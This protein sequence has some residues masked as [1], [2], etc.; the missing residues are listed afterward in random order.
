MSLTNL[1]AVLAFTS[2]MLSF[3]KTKEGGFKKNLWKIFI[4]SLVGL[5]VLIITFSKNSQDANSVKLSDS[6]A[7]SVRILI[8]TIKNSSVI[9]EGKVQKIDTLQ[10]YLR[11][12]DSL[13]I[14]RDSI[15]NLPIVTKN[16][17]NNIR[18]V[19]TLNQY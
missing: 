7:D 12:L 5:A 17:T 19:E 4:T 8:D 3:W 9:I 15:N 6:R 16:F 11:K 18:S 13:G 2:L 14:K 1:L 10:K